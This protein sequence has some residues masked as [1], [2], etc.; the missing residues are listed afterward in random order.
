M[1]PDLPDYDRL[2]IAISESRRLIDETK[3]LLKKSS[4]ILVPPCSGL[5]VQERDQPVVPGVGIE[6]T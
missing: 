6:P 5:V 4:E 3:R 2:A 1:S